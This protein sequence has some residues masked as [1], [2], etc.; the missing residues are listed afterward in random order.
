M[1]PP[2]YCTKPRLCTMDSQTL[3]LS[4]YQLTPKFA[5]CSVVHRQWSF[6][7]ESRPSDREQD[8]IIIKVKDGFGTTSF[9]STIRRPPIIDHGTI[10]FDVLAV[11]ST[12]FLDDST[13]GYCSELVLSI[14]LVR[15]Q[16]F[17]QLR[18]MAACQSLPRPQSISFWTTGTLCVV[19]DDDDTI[20]SSSENMSVC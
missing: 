14:L 19:G 2:C 8:E 10:D 15:C 5:N 18:C 6:D 20:S 4:V 12:I 3:S 11:F 1:M 7:S 17:A 9:K 16:K 13:Q